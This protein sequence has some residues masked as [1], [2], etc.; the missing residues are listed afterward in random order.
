MEKLLNT[1]SLFIQKKNF[2]HFIYLFGF[3]YYYFLVSLSPTYFQDISRKKIEKQRKFNKF[4][5]SDILNND[6][7]PFLSFNLKKNSTIE[8]REISS[9]KQYL[10][11]KRKLFLHH[12]NLV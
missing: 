8:N 7:R 2:I 6:F 12:I 3:C 9:D 5:S 4:K 1:I 10:L 11:N